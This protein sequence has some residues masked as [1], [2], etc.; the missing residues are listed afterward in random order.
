MIEYKD[1][2]VGCPDGMGCLGDACP[3]SKMPLTYCDECGQEDMLYTFP[4]TDEQ[5]CRN[6]MEEA[7]NKAWSEMSFAEKRDVFDAK[8]VKI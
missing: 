3:Y 8:E 1:E 2:C 7:L 4:D 6:C 5:L